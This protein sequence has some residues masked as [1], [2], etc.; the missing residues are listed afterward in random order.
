MA[1]A[2]KGSDKK[3]LLGA[4]LALAQAELASGAAGEAAKIASQVQAEFNK[5]RQPESEWRAALLAAL[6]NRSVGK[7]QLAYDHAA[8]AAAVLTN[9]RSKWGEKFF[10]CYLL[11]PDV[12]HLHEQLHALIRNNQN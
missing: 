6:A 2:E 9:L 1:L 7:R 5:L 11:R 4:R 10:D 8:Q 3:L 12:K